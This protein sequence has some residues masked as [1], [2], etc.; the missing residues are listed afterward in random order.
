MFN[1][2]HQAT[3]SRLKG[4][5]DVFVT[6]AMGIAAVLLVW[7]LADALREPPRKARSPAAEAPTVEEL[8]AANLDVSNA[9]ILGSPSSEVALIEFTDFECPFC[10]RHA[11]DTFK[12]I[13]QEFVMGG[14]VAYIV[15]HFPLDRIHASAIDAAAAAECAGAQGRFW[16]MHHLLFTR[17]LVNADWN[18]FASDTGVGDLNAFHDCMREPESRR[19]IEQDRADGAKLGVVSTPTFF[20][21]KR[22]PDGHVRLTLRV[23]GA[24]PFD[25]FAD[26]LKRVLGS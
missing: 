12:R 16:D 13:E 2:K 10:G 9:R 25:V 21:G 26:A 14:K 11:A 3:M 15:K 24:A 5:L 17:R 4:A 20:V 6:V 1:P 22:L 7:R 23:Q 19:R 18:A 8:A